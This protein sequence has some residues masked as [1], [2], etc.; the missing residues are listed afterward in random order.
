LQK[1]VLALQQVKDQAERHAE[2]R[3]REKEALRAKLAS[4]KKAFESSEVQLGQLAAKITE[5]R[6]ENDK[7]KR[8]KK[9]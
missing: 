7:L 1:K 5:L 4:Q 6:A 3:R 8:S 2:D 9:K